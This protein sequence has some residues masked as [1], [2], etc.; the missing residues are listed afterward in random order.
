MLPIVSDDDIPGVPATIMHYEDCGNVRAESVDDCN[1]D[2]TCGAFDRFTAFRD[3]L[4]V[5]EAT[6]ANIGNGVT[7]SAMLVCQHEM[8][9]AMGWRKGAEWM[10]EK[11]EEAAS[12]CLVSDVQHCDAREHGCR[13]GD[14]ARRCDCECDGCREA[15]WAIRAIPIPD[16]PEVS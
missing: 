14:A 12:A 1:G 7:V 15:C 13:A 3:A 16:A 8:S 4:F 9:S 5:A 10:R 2:C 6:L 11:A